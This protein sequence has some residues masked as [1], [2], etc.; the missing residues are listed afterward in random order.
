MRDFT[1]RLD[2]RGMDW[3]GRIRRKTFLAVLDI[4]V[5]FAGDVL[6]ERTTEADVEAL[7]AVADGQN[8][9]AGGESVLQD[10]E[11]GFFSVRIVVMGLFAAWGTV[12]RWIHV[13][14][15]AREDKGVEIFDLGGEIA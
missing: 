14:R 10:C 5:E 9:F 6:V 8:G 4:G 12:E 2:P 13:V 15:C 3:I 1:A 11:I 7:A